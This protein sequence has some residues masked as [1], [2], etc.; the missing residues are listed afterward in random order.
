MGSE[1]TVVVRFGPGAG[2]PERLSCSQGLYRKALPESNRHSGSF[3]TDCAAVGVTNAGDARDFD[4]L[5]P[6]QPRERLR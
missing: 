2:S 1:L 4:D 6:E 5:A 3:E